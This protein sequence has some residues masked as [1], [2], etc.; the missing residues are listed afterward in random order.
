[1]YKICPEGIQPCNM[2]NRDIFWRTYKI[3]ETLY[4]GQ[5]CLSSL[6]SRLLGPQQFF[7]LPSAAPF[8]GDFSL[9][10]TRS[11]RAPN[12]GSRGAESPGWFDVLLKNS[13]QDVIHERV[14]CH[15]KATNHQLLIA[16][17]FW[18]I[19]IVSVKECSS[20]TQNLIQI[21]CST[22]SDILNVM[23]TQYTCSLNG[24]YHP[25]WPIQWS[26]HCSCICTPVHSPWLLVCINVVQ[27]ILIISTMAG[28]FPDR[29]HIW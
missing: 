23:A 2:K 22:H 26:H 1:M 3:Q 18:I 4:I 7:Q 21:H 29:P 15:D 10:K 25:H 20:L 11:H 17:A 9:G 5:W 19:W 6:Q 14:H 28:L 8:K 12:L 13:A 24:I 27:T 16:A